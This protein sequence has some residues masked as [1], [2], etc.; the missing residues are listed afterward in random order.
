MKQIA[1]V[2]FD[3]T[4]ISGDSTKIFYRSLYKNSIFFIWDYYFVNFMGIAKLVL[5]GD[6]TSLK[7]KRKKKL[8]RN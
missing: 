5:F 4:L 1:V 2:D 7:E 6:H 8:C 3:G